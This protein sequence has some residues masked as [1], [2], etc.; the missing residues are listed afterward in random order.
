MAYGYYGR[1][2]YFSVDASELQQKIALLRN[3]LTKD[4]FEKLI[5]RTFRE[6]GNKSKTL[7][8][9]EV[10]L[11][12]DVQKQWVK[13]QIGRF[14]LKSGTLGGVSCI[15]P[16][17]GKK[18][19]IGGRYHAD[20]K[21]YGDL[22]ASISLQGISVLPDKMKRQGGNPPFMAKGIAFTRRTKKRLPIVSVVGLGVPQMPLNQSKEKVSDQILEYAGNR[23]EHNF[24]FMLGTGK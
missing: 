11:D 1:G 20:W 18:G 7:I 23:L 4:Q 21:R 22:R 16:V 12:Y 17:S 19:S 8:A 6:V 3:V 14:Q 9:D 5:Y 24:L 15:I 13:S 2:A 10:I